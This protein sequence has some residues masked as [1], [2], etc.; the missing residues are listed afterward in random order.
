M[1]LKM[2]LFII[3]QTSGSSGTNGIDISGILSSGD[4]AIDYINYRG[5][6]GAS[7]K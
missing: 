4:N 1:Y 3:H 5:S 7:Y 6:G 2:E